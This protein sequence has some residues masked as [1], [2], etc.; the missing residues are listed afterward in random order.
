MT[1]VS[2]PYHIVAYSTF[3]KLWKTLVPSV[4]I[5]KP[6]SDLCWQCHHNSSAILRAAN[7]PEEEKMIT[8][9]REAQ[10]H[11]RVVQ[12]ERS[13]YKTTYDECRAS[14]TSHFTTDGEFSP[15]SP[16]STVVSVSSIKVHY[17]FNYA[18]QLHY[19]SDP[20]QPGPI[21]FPTP[22]KCTIFGVN[23]EA[24]PRQINF[25]TDEA[26][27]YTKGACECGDQ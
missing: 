12:L 27:D 26:G 9:I 6:M 5:I 23:C 15:P 8:I 18:Q 3:C 1:T 7:R 25:L 4:V 13:Y 22:R 24:I 16:L 19:P 10:K 21:Y 20:L 2:I 14:V 17:S 11:L